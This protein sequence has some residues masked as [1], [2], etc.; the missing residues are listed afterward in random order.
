MLLMVLKATVG[1]T[2]LFVGWVAVE[3]AW[4]RVFRGV[5]E[6]SGC[7]GCIVCSRRCETET[8]HEPTGSEQPGDA[9]LETN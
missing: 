4:R 9:E 8:E 2:A 7:R 3:L 1:V 6:P 5:S